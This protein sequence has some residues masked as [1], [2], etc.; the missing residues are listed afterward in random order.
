[1]LE[2]LTRLFW[3]PLEIMQSLSRRFLQIGRG[4]Y[5]GLFAPA[6]KPPPPSTPTTAASSCQR[7]TT[8]ISKT[9]TSSKSSTKIRNSPSPTVIASCVI[10]MEPEQS[11][12]VDSTSTFTEHQTSLSTLSASCSLKPG[13]VDLELSSTI[14]NSSNKDISEP[15]GSVKADSVTM[16]QAQA[17]VSEVMSAAAAVVCDSGGDYIANRS[18][19]DHDDASIFASES[20]NK[21]KRLREHEK[22]QPQEQ[23]VNKRNVA[24][25]FDSDGAKVDVQATDDDLQS[26]QQAKK[27]RLSE[28]LEEIGS[29]CQGVQQQ[30]NKV[31]KNKK[32]RSK[33]KKEIKPQS[34]PSAEGES[35]IM[36][37]RPPPPNH[38]IAIQISNEDVS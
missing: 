11:P 32:R 30:D 36:P 33:R 27:P 16:T 14:T 8:T 26:T 23:Q 17:I 1:M 19:D 20:I 5:S 15:T 9:S 2:F 10:N 38:F 35:D 31:K 12:G 24:S 21:N 13:L 28:E 4:I 7:D 25:R 37:R 6:I 3:L 29:A 18:S 34:D 22:R